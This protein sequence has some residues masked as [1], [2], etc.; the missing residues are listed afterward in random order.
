MPQNKALTFSYFGRQPVR[1]WIRQKNEVQDAE[2][3]TFFI[4]TLI[5]FGEIKVIRPE[6]ISRISIPYSFFKQKG[7]MRSIVTAMSF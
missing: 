4:N 6:S 1:T 3:R 5:F 7:F 2:V